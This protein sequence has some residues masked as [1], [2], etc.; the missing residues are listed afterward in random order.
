[1][2]W[3]SSQ[4]TVSAARIRPSSIFVATAAALSQLTDDYANIYAY[5]A[6]VVRQNNLVL[7]E[8]GSNPGGGVNS[9]NID[10]QSF[11]GSCLEP[12]Y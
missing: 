12:Y 6:S 5:P 2:T 7:A 10:D 4:P 11:T 9:V 1:M 3:P 8:V